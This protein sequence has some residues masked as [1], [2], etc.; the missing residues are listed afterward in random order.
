MVLDVN[1]AATG[2]ECPVEVGAVGCR[3]ALSHL[4]LQFTKSPL[5]SVL[6]VG[7]RAPAIFK[8][9]ED[10]NSMPPKEVRAHLKGISWPV[11]WL[12]R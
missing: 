12:S 9:R 1:N 3:M 4:A 6:V 2:Q 11:R 7:I 8:G 5:S 10:I